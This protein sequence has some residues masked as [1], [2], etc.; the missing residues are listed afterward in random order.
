MTGGGL[1][2]KIISVIGS[3]LAATLI[4]LVLPSFLNK[5]T[6]AAAASNETGLFHQT[7]IRT[8]ENA[9]PVYKIYKDGDLLGIL[10]DENVLN[11]HLRDV[12]KEKFKESFPDSDAYLA[13]NMYVTKEQSY[14]VYTNADQEILDYIDENNMY[15]VK[16]T[17]VSFSNENGVY[18][19]M[20]V[21]NEE[22]Y[23]EA[24]HQYITMF[25]SPETLAIL[26]AGDAVPELTTYGSRDI[27]ISV[28]QNITTSEE[29]ANPDEVKT[30]IEE[31]LN[32]IEYGDMPEEEKEYYTVQEYDT[33]AG[34]GAKN[35]G[36]S[37]VQVMNLNRDKISSV[38]QV[39]KEGEEL[40]ITYFK[41]IVNIVVYKETLKQEDV[42]YETSIVDDDELL[43]NT[44][45]TIQEGINGSKNTLYSEKWIDG[46]LVSG[47]EKSSVE[48]KQPQTEVIAR[49]TMEPPNV[50]TG[51]F[52]F[53]VDNWII[54]CGWGCYYG[55]R[56]TD[57]QNRYNLW[58]PVLAAD[59]GVI[60]KVSYDSIGGNWVIIDHN[61]GM[62]SYY[63]HMREPS[64]LPVGTVVDKGQQIGWIGMTGWATGPHV[65]FFITVNGERRDACSG[66]LPCY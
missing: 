46:V 57:I 9:V 15:S 41:P 61:N 59:R 55:H 51:V 14:F 44:T 53:P 33:V 39:L 48:T 36:L 11:R 56:G 8:Q 31:V 40:C 24:M 3:F 26:S 17:A 6:E 28:S 45:E 29:Y 52:R 47:V 37:A 23:E 60:S 13:Q 10:S 16:A 7:V 64:F 63:G 32:Y 12:Y 27:G 34:V 5:G 22:L 30:T 19:R 66:F 4:V 2:K 25:I 21:S 35:Y 18:A 42:Y 62:T 50:G 49:G 54:S 58:G 1:T 65:H 43:I 38:D 20:Y